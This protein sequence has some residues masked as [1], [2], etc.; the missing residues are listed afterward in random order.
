MDVNFAVPEGLLD[1]LRDFT[2]NVVKDKPD[3]MEQYAAEYFGKLAAAMHSADSG[4]VDCSKTRSFVEFDESMYVTSD[5][6]V[7]NVDDELD[8]SLRSSQRSVAGSQR[9]RETAAS[10]KSAE[11]RPTCPDEAEKCAEKWA[12]YVQKDSS[13]MHVEK[14]SS[15]AMD[16]TAVE[17]ATS[18]V[19]SVSNVESTALRGS[20]L[21]TDD[22]TARDE[23]TH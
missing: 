16:S 6:R 4:S 21:A 22:S 3:N 11:T 10:A 5:H 20:T 2:V 18:G 8:A 14:D 12:L 9:S 7:G 17:P 19:A 13:L 15:A 23:M 1:L